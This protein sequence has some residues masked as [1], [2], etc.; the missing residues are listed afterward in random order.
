MSTPFPSLA[1]PAWPVRLLQAG[2]WLI[3]LGLILALASGPSYRAALMQLR[4]AF[5]MLA[6]GFVLLITGTL[7]AIVGLLVASARRMRYPRAVALILVVAGLVSSAYLLSW[8]ARARA[9]PPIH[10]VSTDLDDP[11]AFVAVAALRRDA[12]AANPDEYVSRVQGPGGRIIDVPHL[13]RQSYPDIR[14][15]ELPLAPAAAL[16]D[17]RRAA[18]RLGWKIDAYVPAEGRLEA[19]D[20]SA[21]FG[22]KDDIVVRVR[23]AQAGSRIDVRSKSRVG[24]GDVGANARRV[25]AFVGLMKSG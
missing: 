5:L 6:G 1:P 25:R 15:L 7:L 10:E 8:V 22:F 3:G 2:L 13:Q 11:P 18:E 4:P 21:F 19:T 16:T 23:A 20:T 14:P 24:L 12:H 17:A 9:A